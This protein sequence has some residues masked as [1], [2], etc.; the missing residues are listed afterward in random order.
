MEL[1]VAP[2]WHWA[3]PYWGLGFLTV[4]TTILTRVLHRLIIGSNVFSESKILKPE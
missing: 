4:G 3:A 2:V 1:G